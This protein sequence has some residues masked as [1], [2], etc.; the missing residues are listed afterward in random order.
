MSTA[1]RIR[2][3]RSRALLVVLAITMGACSSSLL[4]PED[5]AYEKFCTIYVS[6]AGANLMADAL[7]NR[8]TRE[9]IQRCR[10]IKVF[11]VEFGDWGVGSPPLTSS[12][13]TRRPNL[14]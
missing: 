4:G 6:E 7:R 9:Q 1:C 11:V 12:A 10:P 5:T 8:L 2:I 13:K 3:G 14:C